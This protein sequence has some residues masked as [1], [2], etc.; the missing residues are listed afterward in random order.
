MNLLKENKAEITADEAL[1]LAAI[2]S[3][4][5]CHLFGVSIPT[6]YR[7]ISEG[8]IPTVEPLGKKM[9]PRSFYAKYLEA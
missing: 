9:I 3:K 7:R 1:Q 6:L 2:T 5:F 8:K 4:Q